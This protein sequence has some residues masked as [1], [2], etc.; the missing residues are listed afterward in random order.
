MIVNRFSVLLEQLEE[1]ELLQSIAFMGSAAQHTD[2]APALYSYS[3]S[4]A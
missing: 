4:L 1:S 3:R 2:T